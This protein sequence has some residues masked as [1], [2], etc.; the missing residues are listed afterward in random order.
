[1]PVGRSYG[2]YSSSYVPYHPPASV[3][4]T[5]YTSYGRYAL[6]ARAT[7]P[8]L[9]E[10]VPV[11]APRSSYGRNSP[12]SYKYLTK[13]PDYQPVS[14]IA[15]QKVRTINTEDLD[16]ESKAVDREHAIPGTIRRDT[17]A[18]L[19][20]RG[21]QVVRM[22]TNNPRT[23]KYNRSK[24]QQPE[25]T[26]GQRLALKHL[27][28][29][30]REKSKSPPPV[31]RSS[32]GVKR[33]A[34]IEQEEDEEGSSDD[35]TWETCSSS[36]EGPD[37]KYFPPTPPRAPT[38]EV[39]K[40][41]S[42]A[43]SKTTNL[44]AAIA[45]IAKDSPAIDSSN[46]SRQSLD[47]WS[48]TLF[49]NRK[50][51][52]SGKVGCQK[53]SVHKSKSPVSTIEV[54]PSIPKPVTVESQI[55]SPVII[56]NK[57][58]LPVTVSSSQRTEDTK[59]E[60]VSHARGIDSSNHSG[61]SSDSPV[62]TRRYQ[63]PALQKQPGPFS[64]DSDS[65]AGGS[66]T[67]NRG[68]RRG[69]P[70]RSDVVVKLVKNK[71][72]F[73]PRQCSD[74]AVAS[75]FRHSK[76]ANKILTSSLDLSTEKNI[77]PDIMGGGRAD[78]S[79]DTKNAGKSHEVIQ[80][81]K[82][83]PIVIMSPP[84][85][86]KKHNLV[87]VRV[88]LMQCSEKQSVGNQGQPVVEGKMELFLEN[89]EKTAGELKVDT[90]LPDAQC[91]ARGGDDG[92]DFGGDG[93]GDG[94]LSHEETVLTVAHAIDEV[95]AK[96]VAVERRE[97]ETKSAEGHK[98]ADQETSPSERREEVAE[99]GAGDVEQKDSDEIAG[100]KNESATALL[101]DK[102]VHISATETIS[103]AIST[104]EP[105]CEEVTSK[106]NVKTAQKVEEDSMLMEKLSPKLITPNVSPSEKLQNS[107]RHSVEV[108]K[109]ET[110]STVT[111]MGVVE[112][113]AT[114][115][116]KMPLVDLKNRENL[117]KN[118]EA[119]LRQE[120][121]VP[122]SASSSQVSIADSSSKA[123]K[124]VKKTKATDVGKRDLKK[125][126]KR[127]RKPVELEE[128]KV[129]TVMPLPKVQSACEILQQLKNSLAQPSPSSK[130]PSPP[131]CPE[132]PECP[133]ERIPSPMR[134]FFEFKSG[135]YV[136]PSEPPP[137]VPRPKYWDN[138]P[139]TPS[140]DSSTNPLHQLAAMRAEAK[141]H[142]QM[143]AQEQ[144]AL[145]SAPTDA[146]EPWYEEESEETKAQLK[147]HERRPSDH[148]KPEAE[149]RT[150]EENMAVM[151]LYGGAQ[152]PGGQLDLTPKR[153]LLRNQ[154]K[155]TGQKWL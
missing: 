62:F 99:K 21:Q 55:H 63:P 45:E 131:P 47:R 32:L 9:S 112:K 119:V 141:R 59:A 19:G 144:A 52:Q 60:D 28:L 30:P 146:S 124:K 2:G 115:P 88:S 139:P 116:E 111:T 5:S 151:K 46:V 117:N 147:V 58:P 48:R 44:T 37:V 7:T 84:P 104:R 34:F 72:A 67:Y 61:G 102:D 97:R 108:P 81:L 40:S 140:D 133:I 142:Q 69:Q 149:R 14:E 56:S 3:Y 125:E 68:W 107:S 122:L 6:A 143:V 71:E 96:V 152:F 93:G 23:Y 106:E 16:V 11:Q 154:H 29:D 80:V 49:T 26:L 75:S 25:L 66:S 15:P 109:A 129:K 27:L 22:V 127:P 51:L 138:K 38:P 135:L 128:N 65:D 100:V 8:G 20:S 77:D 113:E 91:Q 130:P 43:R 39:K 76:E 85:P 94:D 18:D 17:T 54:S 79:E 33:S 126:A 74:P 35:W 118:V 120:K 13:G 73:K 57:S 145:L 136:P 153:L 1:M 70:P 137:G 24:D 36:E 4:A 101:I 31:R 121:L 42:G 83:E 12:A 110:P 103:A 98:K 78:D 87:T 64:S 92:G 105:S 95:L 155:A 114:E 82:P 41:Y 150:V 86:A 132:N 53:S 90:S 148:H 89:K 10:D 50:N 123:K 134:R